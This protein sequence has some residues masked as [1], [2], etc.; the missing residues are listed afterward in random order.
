MLVDPLGDCFATFE[1]FV[2]DA[3]N[4]TTTKDTFFAVQTY[5]A[6]KN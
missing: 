3:L 6:S 4:T 5:N 2:L 1:L